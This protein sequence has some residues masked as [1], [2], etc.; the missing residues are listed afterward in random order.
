MTTAERSM[1]SR[2]I[3]WSLPAHI[4]RCQLFANNQYLYRTPG[5]SPEPEPTSCDLG[6]TAF[7][8]DLLSVTA[9]NVQ[10]GYKPQFAL[11]ESK[12]VYRAEL[13]S[14]EVTFTVTTE[15]DV[16]SVFLEVLRASQV[17]LDV[18]GGSGNKTEVSYCE[19][20]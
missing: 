7:G 2:L 10:T 20:V 13:N 5:A 6:Y 19:Y 17:I 18:I 16:Q 12:S 11:S 3:P 8:D 4:E 1:I 9:T 14:G 15:E